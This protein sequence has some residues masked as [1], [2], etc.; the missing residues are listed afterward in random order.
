M[1]GPLDVDEI[2]KFLGTWGRY[3]RGQ[4]FLCLFSVI[5]EALHI[6]S[7]VFLTY[8]PPFECNVTTASDIFPH[9]DQNNSTYRFVYNKCTIDVFSNDTDFNSTLITSTDCVSGYTYDEPDDVSIVTE[10]NL[11]C[12]GGEKAELAQ[13]LVILGQGIGAVI[14]TTLADMYG[15]KPVHILCHIAM[16]T[17]SLCTAWSPSPAVFTALRFLLGVFQAGTGLTVAVAAMETLP[18][19]SRYLWDTADLLFWTTGCLLVTPIAYAFRNMSWRSMQIAFAVGSAYS[20]LEYWFLEESLRWL[21]A[22]NKK[23]QAE[24]IIRMAARMN[25]KD[26]NSVIKAASTKAKEM[27]TFLSNNI[28]PTVTTP[29]SEACMQNNS[30]DDLKPTKP[31][32]Y[33]A[34]TI[35]KHKRIL[36]NSLIIWYTWTTDSLVYYA[37]Y[38]SSMSL[39]GDRFV[40]FFLM[41][42]VEY[43]AAA[44]QWYFIKRFGRR[45]PCVI[46]HTVAGVSLAV[47]T[48][49]LVYQGRYIKF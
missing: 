20:L 35:F 18:V 8:R 21:L 12:D 32:K 38:L 47:S 17:V 16:F 43:P 4:I 1:D 15:R 22:N 45:N 36:L 25:G 10:W 44:T 39:S 2:W 11:F 29:T 3:Q 28:T 19:N 24:K 49:C 9:E 26:F 23:D 41:G 46:F 31:E 14:F 6:I 13:S 27:E 30:K 33:N 48:V 40:N 7:I 37:L 5:P 42:L 34:F